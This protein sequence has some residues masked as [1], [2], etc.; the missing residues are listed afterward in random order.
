MGLSTFDD[1]L[2]KLE[3]TEENL[4]SLEQELNRKQETI[5][6]LQKYNILLADQIKDLDNTVEGFKIKCDTLQKER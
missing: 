3:I 6:D 1:L 2:I 5:L 4:A